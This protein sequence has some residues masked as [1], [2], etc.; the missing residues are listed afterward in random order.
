MFVFIYKNTPLASKFR[1]FKTT[2]IAYRKGILRQVQRLT[3][4][5]AERYGYYVNHHYQGRQSLFFS[6]L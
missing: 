5:P 6:S 2:F 4:F 1:L 3:I